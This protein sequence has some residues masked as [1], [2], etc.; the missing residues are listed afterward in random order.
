[1]LSELVVLGAVGDLACRHL[2]P[3]LAHLLA[4][5]ILPPKFRVSGV[6][7][8]ALT[9]ETY[10][11]LAARRLA[12]HAPTV[13]SALRAALVQHLNYLQADVEQG[14]DLRPVL[15]SG[16]VIAYLALPPAVYAPAV[17]ALKAGGIE[18]GSRIVVEKPFG[19][20]L[21]SARKLSRLLH[22]VVPEDSVFRAD[23]FLHHQAVQDIIALRFANPFFEPL[24]DRDHIERVEITWEEAAGVSGRADFYDRTGA[25]RD[26]VQSHLLQVL[27]LL[28]MDGPAT[29]D[30]RLVRDAKVSVLR[31]VRSFTA[32]E[33]ATRTARG[34]YT[35]GTLGNLAVGSYRDETG[36]N[37][38]RGTETYAYVQLAIDT[39]RW[40]GVPFILRT[41]KALGR[42]CRRVVVVFRD[43]PGGL[44]SGEAAMLC[45]E[46]APDRVA[47]KLG[48][49]SP[50]GLPTIEPAW[51]E[52]SRPRQPLPASAR[53]LR[54]V[55]AG[56]LT[57]SVRDDEAEECWRITDSVLRTWRTG[58][59]ALQSYPAGS[60]GPTLPCVEPAG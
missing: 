46:M 50:S 13:D 41:G 39:P 18:A 6:G 51:L 9:N 45:V 8:E 59:P 2:L 23:H 11:D 27:A 35:A 12:E 60:S 21:G 42:P 44:L 29:L 3:A 7:R 56:D 36:V 34:R 25:L 33:V 30:Q 53:L 20:N 1:V 57:R 28:A 52:A 47:L 14:P 22:T 43:P 37:L 55:L 32:G 19:E 54:D 4:V 15:A 17:Q 38:R 40:Q 31:S 26:M 10:R 58:V 48:T 49:A 16:P 5:G 24:W